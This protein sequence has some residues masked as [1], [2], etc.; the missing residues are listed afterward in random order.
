MIKVLLFL[1]EQLNLILLEIIHISLIFPSP[2]L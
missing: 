2:N 1:L